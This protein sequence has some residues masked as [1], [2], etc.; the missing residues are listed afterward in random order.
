MD[1]DLASRISKELEAIDPH[2]NALCHLLD[3]VEN[4]QLREKMQR[5]IA[6]VIADLYIEIMRPIEREHPSLKRD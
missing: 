2:L 1:F 4:N 6:G 5:G 3:R